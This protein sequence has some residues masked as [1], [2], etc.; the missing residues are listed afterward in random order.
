GIGNEWISDHQ[1]SEWISD[2]AGPL[3]TKEASKEL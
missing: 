2:Q 1:T 3:I